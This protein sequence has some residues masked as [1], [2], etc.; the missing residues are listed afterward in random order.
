MSRIFNLDNWLKTPEKRMRLIRIIYI[1]S[2]AMLL[3]GFI[4]IIISFIF[5][6]FLG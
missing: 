1:I 4:L 2:Y 3:L 6:G 5:P